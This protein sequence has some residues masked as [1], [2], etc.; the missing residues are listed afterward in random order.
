MI[1]L[2]FAAACAAFFP[3]V[4]Q[5]PLPFAIVDTGQVTCFNDA[6]AIPFPA[7]GEKYFG[8][9][10][11]YLINPALYQKNGDGT[12]SDQV[13][14]LM[15]TMDLGEKQTL[16]QAT[17]GAR[18]CKVGGHTDWRLPSIKELYSL[19]QF[20]GIDPGPSDSGGSGRTP[21]IDT[22]AFPGFRY[23]NA[24][25]GE[26]VIDAQFATRTRYVST[27]MDGNPTMFGVNFADGRIKGYPITRRRGDGRY[28]V[29]YVR[30]NTAYGENDFRDNHD[31]TVTDKA[32]GL[33]WMQ[34]DSG[35]GMDW[36][37]ALAYAESLDL[38]EHDD[39]RLP[40]AKELQSIVDYSRSPDTTGSAAIAPV[41][42]ATAIKNEGGEKDY[43]HYW[44]STSHRGGRGASTA[45]YLAF[46]RALGFMSD[47][48]S[49]TRRLLDVH[50]A[51]AQRS[52]P[53]SGDASKFPLGRGPQGDVIRIENMVRCVRGGVV[54]KVESTDD[55]AV[56]KP[57]RSAQ[58]RRG[59]PG[60]GG[61]EA[62]PAI[63]VRLF[64]LRFDQNGDGQVTRDEFRGPSRRFIRLDENGDGVVTSQETGSAA[65]GQST[66]KVL[67]SVAPKSSIPPTQSQAGSNKPPNIILI[68]ADDIGWTGLSVPIDDRIKE[69]QSDFYQTP[70]IANLAEAGMRFSNAYAP[71]ALCT[72][73]RASILT[74]KTPAR[75]HITT[76]GGGGR[77]AQP[78]RKFVGP[79][80]LHEL[81]TT[82]TTIAEALG[83]AG[84]AS[85]HLGKW[86]LG[87]RGPGEYGFDLHDGATANDGPAAFLDPNPKDIFGMTE[88]AIAFMEKQAQSN[89]PFYLQLSHYAA[90]A[91][92]EALEQTKKKFAML[93]GGD[94]HHNA[95]YAAMIYDLDTSVGLLLDALERLDL[96][97][98]TYVIFMS[99]NGATGSRHRPQNEPLSGGK[100]SLNEGGIRVPLIVRGPGIEPG[101]YSHENVIGYD[102]YPSFC[103][104]AGVDSSTA[105]DGVSL[106]PL[107]QGEPKR[108]NRPQKALLF[109]FPHY[110]QGPRQTPQSAIL[111]GDFKLIRDYEQGST[112]LYNLADDISEKRDLSERE[113]KLAAELQ[114]LLDQR[115]TEATAQMP[116]VNPGYDPKAG[117]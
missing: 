112:R 80:P 10:A 79:R 18:R 106:L 56:P 100:G 7:P 113:P 84:Y 87:N 66:P 58:G 59:P 96:K 78:S 45:V 70:N 8:Q 62:A 57:E 77:R 36:S 9:D 115:L 31:G 94:R 4:A 86:H 92:V 60:R 53:K 110:G 41:F 61:A 46:G 52:D 15:W 71:A 81:P 111:L 14:G 68:L 98:S 39:W 88:R 11:H 13:T 72:P 12:V 23:G 54:E 22:A 102:L 105:S 107:L 83:R 43:G 20:S 25:N 34:S 51:G 104:W 32:S 90:H 30:G 24:D 75:L 99:D 116:S 82:E 85:A 103:A 27:T 33:T 26:R 65:H 108:F 73:S 89:T 1:A 91:P 42:K 63:D 21:F 40:T 37:D 28:F 64:I 74:G 44:T 49:E 117:N 29:M 93:P 48:R 38:A 50:G 101:S 2:T 95:E 17:E 97:D 3:A 47:R 114:A 6:V 5:E 76:P 19:I 35:K 69:S 55:G 67:E 16:V 109:H